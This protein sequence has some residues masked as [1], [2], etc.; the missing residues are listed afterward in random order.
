MYTNAQSLMAHKDEI[1]HQI[2]KK[3]NPAVIALSESRLIAEISNSEINVTGYSVV[4]CDAENRNTGGVALYVRDDV[5]Y[6]IILLKKLERNAWCVA[7]EL[8]EKMFKGVV[9]LIYHSPSASH[10]EFI[11]FLE[12]IVEE[13]TIKKECIILGDFNIDCM[14]G[15][16][17]TNKLM[18]TMQSLGMKQYVD[19]PTR[20]TENSKTIIDLVFANK[21]LNVQVT[22]EPKITDHAW[23]KVVIHMSKNVNKYKEFRGRD[24]CRFNAEEFIKRVESNLGTEQELE[25]NIR[26][27]KLINSIVDALDISAPKKIFRIPKVWEGKKWYSEEIEELAIK[28]DEAYR[29]ALYDS[30]EQNWQHFKIARNAIVKLIRI[31]KKEYYE[32]MI[33]QNSNSPT[34][35]WKSLKEIIRGGPVDA[36]VAENIDFEMLNNNMECGIADKFNL[37]YIQS[38]KD[39]IKTI[40]RDNI[41]SAD[42]RT[43]FCI[44][45]KGELEKFELITA[46]QLEVIIRE[47]PK[48]KGT[49][50]GITSDILKMVSCVI[51]KEYCDIINKSLSEGCFLKEWKTSTIIPIPKIEKPEKGSDYRPIN[52][53]P[54]YEKVLEIVVKRQIESYLE[55]NNIITEH[56]SGFRKNYSCETAIQTVIDEWKL[57]IS[58]RQMVGV[59][60]MDLKRAFE[61][62]DRD[63]LLV[64][65]FQYGI[66]GKVLEW[67]RSYLKD[68]RQQV[69]VNDD[70]SAMLATEY[71]VPQ[72]SVLG[73]LLFIIYINDII[74]V[75]AEVCSIK[76]FADDTLIYVTG[77][78]STELERKLNIAFNGVEEWMNDNK[79]KMNAVKTKYMIVRSIRKELRG[80]TTVKCLDGNEIERVEVMKYLGVIIDDRLRF[81]DHCNYMLKKIGKKIS[82]LNRIG[83]DISAYTRCIIY[84]TIIAPHFEYCATLLINM[85]DTQLSKLQKAQNRAMRVILQCDRR[86]KI[87]CMLQALQF[88]TVR[89]RLYYN[90]CIFIFKVLNNMLPEQLSNRLRIVGEE[91]ERQTRQ[92][93]DIA[94]EFR[95]T[96]SAQKSLFY[97]GLLMYN[98]LPAEIKHCDRFEQFRR[99]L[100]EFVMNEVT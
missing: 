51:R 37:Y 67:F 99:M 61:T 91:R 76:M 20:V 26:A 15:S 41:K 69:K 34:S 75:C 60:F 68:R 49:E 97:E 87:E 2:M 30:T 9:M 72:G 29:K 33:D 4:R 40:Y 12:E 5:K 3:L 70:W 53:L 45:K 35:M 52:I 74:K 90:M 27:Y 11:G 82:F 89:Q 19:T 23:I 78:S 92:A 6:E 21:E 86:T 28:R 100:K 50:E 24:Y 13:L 81:S 32:R 80:D 54:I 55:S 98:A 65:L 83:N 88:M 85:G 8:E 38:I 22:Y 66:S 14:T 46:E 1:Q 96:R 79:L 10:G 57:I 25:I 31:K 7:I 47:L 43:I 17:Y 18:A 71:G 44:E 42:K 16:F 93:G 63:R 95:R 94:I 48:K 36:K 59:I 62:I 77:E 58:E 64:K 84:K 39:I 56:Q 73:P